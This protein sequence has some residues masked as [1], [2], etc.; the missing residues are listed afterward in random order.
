MEVTVHIETRNNSQKCMRKVG[1]SV[2]KQ[3]CRLT[4]TRSRNDKSGNHFLTDDGRIRRRW[5]THQR[6]DNIVGWS[7]D[8]HKIWWFCPRWSAKGLNKFKTP[9]LL[10]YICR[11]Y[12]IIMHKAC[13]S[14]STLSKYIMSRSETIAPFIT[15]ISSPLMTPAKRYQVSVLRSSTYPTK[16]PYRSAWLGSCPRRD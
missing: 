11:T 12:L 13:S 5:R 14:W 16:K 15:I 2:F 7:H 10:A 9:L 4:P 3:I 1:W 8:S 6:L